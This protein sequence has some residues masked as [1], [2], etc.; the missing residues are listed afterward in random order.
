M[1]IVACDVVHSVEVLR[2]N[3]HTHAFWI[4]LRVV[5]FGFESNQGSVFCCC[6]LPKWA[7]PGCE[8]STVC[9]GSSYTALQAPVNDPAPAAL[10]AWAGP[11]ACCRKFFLV[12]LTKIKIWNE[13]RFTDLK[14]KSSSIWE[15]MFISLKR[16]INFEK[17]HQFEKKS[18]KLKKSSS[19]LAKVH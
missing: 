14:N 18:F 13:E 4:I 3:P 7:S 10:L 19:N 6:A 2:S 11:L 8:A 17:V 12:F 15:N 5:R 9:N 1:Y 16:F